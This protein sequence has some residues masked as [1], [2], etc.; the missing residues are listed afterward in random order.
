M[1]FKTTALL[2]AA[3]ATGCAYTPPPRDAAQDERIRLLESQLAQSESD[4]QLAAAQTRI[5]SLERKLASIAAK[6]DESAKVPPVVVEPNTPPPAEAKPAP[7][8]SLITRDPRIAIK[9]WSDSFRSLSAKLLQRYKNAPAVPANVKKQGG[10]VGKP[11]AQTR[12]I[13]PDGEIVDLNDLMG[14]KRLVLVV[15]RGFFGQVC[16]ACSTQTLALADAEEKFTSR[17]AQVVLIYPGEPA[18]IPAFL[19]ATKNLRENFEL[20][21]PVLLDANLNAVKMFKIE[22]DLAKPTSI[23]VDEKGIVRYAYVGTRYDDRP[24]IETLLAQL[25]AIGPP[26]GK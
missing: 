25:D 2:V 9:P 7:A 5:D 19:D 17:N 13:G 18:S 14:K 22:G 8:R 23:I 4:R 24:G 16:I 21:Y 20:H 26:D 11:L 6:L 1:N 3:L 15:M 10:L 12:F